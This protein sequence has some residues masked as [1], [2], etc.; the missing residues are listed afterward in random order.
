MHLCSGTNKE[1]TPP[2]MLLKNTCEI[3]LVKQTGSYLSEI[4]V[5]SL[6]LITDNEEEACATT[7]RGAWVIVVIGLYR[8]F[9]LLPSGSLASSSSIVT[10]SE[11]KSFSHDCTSPA[12]RLEATGPV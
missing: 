7:V 9:R 11:S 6:L 10:I 8:V 5:S 3:I 2:Q 4:F 1:T 12:V